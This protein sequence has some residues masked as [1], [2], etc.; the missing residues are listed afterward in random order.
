LTTYSAS[1]TVNSGT[2]NINTNALY[3][4]SS[5]TTA[6]AH[7][8]ADTFSNDQYSQFVVAAA[9]GAYQGPAVRIAASAV[10]AYYIWDQPGDGPYLEKVITGSVTTLASGGGTHAANTNTMYLKANG[11]TITPMLNGSA[12]SGIA[13][14]TDS[15]ITS[16]SAGGANLNGGVN[17]RLDSWE[18]GNLTPPM[19]VLLADYSRFPKASMRLGARSTA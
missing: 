9:G 10:T 18:G 2:W 4:S 19:V 7:W 17:S 14:Q 1:W 8:N 12:W 11:T 6:L 15:S 13:A 3:T 5:A 16:G